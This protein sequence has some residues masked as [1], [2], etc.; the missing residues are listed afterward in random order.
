MATVKDKMRTN[1]SDGL[2]ECN[3]D[4]WLDQLR[5]IG[6]LLKGSIK[7]KHGLRQWKD[8]YNCQF[9]KGSAFNWAEWSRQFI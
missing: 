5:A 2:G 6:S 8:I 9:N 4:E 3:G 1:I 7:N